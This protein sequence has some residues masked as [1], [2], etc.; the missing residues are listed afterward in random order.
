MTHYYFIIPD[1]LIAQMQGYQSGS[2]IFNAVQ[3]IEG[4]W[5]CSI[6]SVVEFP[7]LFEGNAFEVVRLGENDFEKGN[8]LEI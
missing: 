4:R 2:N 1:N 8:P 7:E 3:D 6:N 5:V